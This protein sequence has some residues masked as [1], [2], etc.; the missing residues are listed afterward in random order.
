[1]PQRAIAP[2]TILTGTGIALAS[3]SPRY[4]PIIFIVPL[5]RA[6]DGSARPSR[7]EK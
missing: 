2:R 4:S 3:F 6:L 5:K 1:V 7:M